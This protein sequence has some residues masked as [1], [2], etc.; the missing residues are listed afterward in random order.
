LYTLAAGAVCCGASV[1]AAP[2]VADL[3]PGAFSSARW[4][5]RCSAAWS[6]SCSPSPA[7]ARGRSSSRR[8]RRKASRSS[9]SGAFSTWRPRATWSSESFRRLGS[10][11]GKAS[12]ARVLGYVNLNAD[13]FLIARFLGAVPLGV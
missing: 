2:L 8:L 6:A 13:N 7:S 11:A 10:F 3:S 1:A 4:R 12:G 9:S 5:G